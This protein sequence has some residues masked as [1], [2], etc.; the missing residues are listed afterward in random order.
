LRG[1]RFMRDHGG[2]NPHCRCV[3]DAE[4]LAPRAAP[5]PCPAPPIPPAP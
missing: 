5:K 1:A 4:Y 2:N 3:A